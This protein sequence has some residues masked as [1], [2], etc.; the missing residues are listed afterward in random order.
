MTSLL[1]IT[2]I[3]RFNNMLKKNEP[4]EYNFVL[5]K[6]LEKATVFEFE[7]SENKYINNVVSLLYS[8]SNNKEEKYR[9]FDAITQCRQEDCNK[10]LEE[11][12]KLLAP[13]KYI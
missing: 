10:F 1:H 12:C 2:F 4:Y 9:L 11:L 8:T 3:S 13:Y 7:Y 5:N 6:L